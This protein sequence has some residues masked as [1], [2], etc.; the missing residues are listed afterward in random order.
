[1]YQDLMFGHGGND[2]FIANSGQDTLVGGSGADK[3]VNFLILLQTRQS[4]VIMPRLRT[5]ILCR[6]SFLRPIPT[7]GPV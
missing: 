2:F 6:T 4:L 1:M 5:G 3:F 7:L